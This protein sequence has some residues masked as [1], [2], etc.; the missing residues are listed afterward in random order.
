MR[1]CFV[2]SSGWITTIHASNEGSHAGMSNCEPVHLGT[3]LMKMCKFEHLLSFIVVDF[4]YGWVSRER[5]RAGSK[6][7]TGSKF[8]K[9][10]VVREGDVTVG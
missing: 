4:M 10:R 6:A 9:I 3:R 1:G 8:M 5:T 2:I 7:G